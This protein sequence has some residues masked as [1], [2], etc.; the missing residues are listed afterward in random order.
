MSFDFAG[1]NVF[2]AGRNSGI[3]LG[4]ALA[5]A[6]AG[7]RVAVLSRSQDKVDTA[8][9]KLEA[10]RDGAEAIGFPAR[11]RPSPA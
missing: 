11:R 3:N 6:E 4:I 1:K 9:E 5:F 7:A 10:A 2:V 8:V